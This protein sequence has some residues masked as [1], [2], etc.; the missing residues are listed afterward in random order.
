MG[1]LKDYFSFSKRD[2]TGAIV[3]IIL[4]VFIFLLPEF[5]PAPKVSV[6]R[7]AVAE[8]QKQTA[9]LKA[10]DK[11][12]T[13]AVEIMS[14]SDYEKHATIHKKV[15]LF[16]FDPNTISADGWRKLGVNDRTIGTIR[17]YISKGGSFRKPRDLERIYG[18]RKEQYE[19]LAPF[20]RIIAQD[21]DSGRA[22]SNESLRGYKRLVPP[23]PMALELNEADTS[24]LIALPGIG[25]KLASRIINFRDK[26]GGFYSVEQVADVYG[27]PDS[28]FQM[29]RV[30]LRCDS[31]QI[32]KLNVNTADEAVLKN[33][34]YIKWNLARAIVNYRQQHGVYSSLDKLM[35]I[36]I[37]SPDI[38]QKISPYLKAE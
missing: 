18:L 11:D 5:Y 34:P 35:Q 8:F 12:S 9:G 4:I 14:S 29:V 31:S 33:H 3:L 32:E 23:I 38:F 24:M 25:S 30:F 37:I 10:V 7:D 17:K 21:D 28:T 2:R 20:V 15:Q 1:A 22:Q 36:D 13:E 26:L 27:L 6:D 16:Y 19:Q